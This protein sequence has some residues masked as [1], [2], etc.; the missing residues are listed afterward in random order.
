VDHT[1]QLGTAPIFRLVVK[2]SLPTIFA[3]IVNAIYNIVDRIFVGKFVGEA[4]LGGLTV[5]FPLMIIG[6]AVGTLFAIGGA[7]LISIKFGEHKLDEANK[8]FGNVAT[9]ILISSLLMTVLGEIFLAPLLGLAGSTDLSFG[10]A[11][12]YMRII[13]IGLVFQLSSF[14]MAA[15]VRSEGKPFLSMISQVLSAVTNIVLDYIFIGPLNMGVEGA[16]LATII[17]QM[18][19]FFMLFYFYF[20]SKKSLLKLHWDTLR[21]RWVYM[22]Q[23]MLIGASSFIINL[24]TGISASFTNASLSVYGGDAA[25]TSF[26]A[27]NSLFTLVLMPVLGLLQGIGPIMGYNHGMRQHSRVWKTLWTGIGLGCIFTFSLFALMEIFPEAFASL[28][29][30]PASPTMAVCAHGL[31]LQMLALPVL[32]F[33]VLS[34]AYFQSTAQ[35]KKSFFISLLRQLLVIV[36]VLVLPQYLQLSGVWLAGPFS[37]VLSLMVAASMLIADRRARRQEPLPMEA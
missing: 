31:R 12:S 30:D 33:S 20:I 24:G 21:L 11:S 7:T 4:A 15:I 5:S 35:G 19:G 27:I 36:G 22:R 34:T 18:V 29:L 3:M 23:I 25:L 14:T 9:L 17:G 10:Y 26:G 28:F 2:F 1:K 6:F 13:I 32:S 8:I 37:E 16:A